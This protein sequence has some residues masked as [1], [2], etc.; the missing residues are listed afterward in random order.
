MTGWIALYRCITEHWIWTT[1]SRRLQRW[2]DLLFMATWQP[3]KEVFFANTVVPLKRGQIVTS[4]RALMQR[5]NTNNHIVSET[6]RLFEA[7]GMIS[8]QR[9]RKMMVITVCNYAKYQYAAIAAQAILA[10]ETGL[11]DSLDP[12]KNGQFSADS[13]PFQQQNPVQEQLQNWLLNKQENNKII[14]NNSNTTREG[15]LRFFEQLKVDDLSIEQA[16]MALRCERQRILELL[17]AFT[18]DINFKETAHA[19]L[20]DFKK[21]FLDWA[22]YQVRN[23][24]KDGNGRKKSKPGG[25]G[26]A[27]DKYAARRGTDVGNHTAKDYSGSF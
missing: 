3:S 25:E 4:V 22:R 11:A 7:A 21:H 19:D 17:E 23:E 27:E 12:S 6:L 16:M 14:N 9:E 8:C 20:K 15:N 18:H 10:A 24:K 13:M 1:S 26:G 5:W 2:I